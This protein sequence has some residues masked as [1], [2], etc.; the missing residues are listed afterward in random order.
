MITDWLSLS[1]ENILKVQTSRLLLLVISKTIIAPSL[2][3][4]FTREPT[5]L[6]KVHRKLP[7]RPRRDRHALGPQ[8][9]SLVLRPRWL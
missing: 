4:Q 1:K 7:Q 2:R 5:K 6:I 8:S 9:S 3:R